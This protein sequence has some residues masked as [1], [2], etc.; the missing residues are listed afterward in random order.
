[1]QNNNTNIPTIKAIKH[2]TKPNTI[3]KQYNQQSTIKQII[4]QAI[5]K[6]KPNRTTKQR[7]NNNKQ[8]N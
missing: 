8:V 1:M 4:S 2:T 6:A 3:N 5:T 7:N